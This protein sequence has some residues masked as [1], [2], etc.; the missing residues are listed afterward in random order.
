MGKRM[1][2]SSAS[3][4]EL[5][6]RLS[7]I[8]RA[9]LPAV[10]LDP[11]VRSLTL[12]GA[13]SSVTKAAPRQRAITREMLSTPT[14]RYRAL[15]PYARA[16]ARENLMSVGRP[17][18]DR[19]ARLVIS[20]TNPRRGLTVDQAAEEI[21]ARFREFSKERA[22]LIA[23]TETARMHSFAHLVTMMADGT[24]SKRWLT[25]GQSNVCEKCLRNSMVG[26]VPVG[27]EFP[28]GSS[29]PPAHPNCV[30]YLV[31]D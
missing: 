5:A 8:L 4:S 17:L 20:T 14:K 19:L 23:R 29:F 6:S 12:A 16:L 3:E 28:D 2:G 31:F 9:R 26:S 7:V 15:Y 25:S 22:L 30:C 13:R 10:Q 24:P 18:A 27:D 21:R 11:I 1:W